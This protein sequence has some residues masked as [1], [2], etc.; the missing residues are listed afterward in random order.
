MILEWVKGSMRSTVFLTMAR[1]G[2]STAKSG[3]GESSASFL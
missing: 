3:G 2:E 1:F